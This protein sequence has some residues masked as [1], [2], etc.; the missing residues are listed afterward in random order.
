MAAR[1]VNPAQRVADRT[2]GDSAAMLELR[3]RCLARA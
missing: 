2:R 1:V 3:S